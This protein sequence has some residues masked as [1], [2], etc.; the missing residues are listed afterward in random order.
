M[1]PAIKA[2][3]ETPGTSAFEKMKELTRRVV[4]VPKSTVSSKRK[5]T[6]KRHP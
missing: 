2:P 6:R 4:N 3:A 1:K 5:T